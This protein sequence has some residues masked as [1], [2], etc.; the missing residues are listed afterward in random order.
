MAHK[1]NNK[2]GGCALRI[3]MNSTKLEIMFSTVSMLGLRFTMV[4]G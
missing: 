2:D 3:I 4:S 1:G